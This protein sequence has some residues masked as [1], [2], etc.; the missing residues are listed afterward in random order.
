MQL[1]RTNLQDAGCIKVA[2][3]L[4]SRCESLTRAVEPARTLTCRFAA[5]L[6]LKLLGCHQI[7]V[8]GCHQILAEQCSVPA[9]S[10]ISRL[11]LA[12]NAVRTEGARAVAVLLS[13]STSITFLNLSGNAIGVHGARAIADAIIYKVSAQPPMT[14]CASA[15]AI[16]PVCDCGAA[17]GRPLGCR[18]HW[19]QHPR[20]GIARST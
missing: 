17:S 1:A 19:G 18:K 5:R 4:Q 3:S 7:N 10:S 2:A 13:S 9:C 15:T 6:C 16:V 8:L 11:Y 20:H 12:H 14:N